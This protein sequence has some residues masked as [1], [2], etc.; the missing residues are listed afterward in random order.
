MTTVK[1]VLE[2]IDSLIPHP[3]EMESI[4]LDQ[5]LHR[6]L[7][8]SSQAMEDQP[9]FHRSSID[10]YLTHPDQ[11]TGKVRLLS[12]HLPKAPT[13]VLPSLITDCP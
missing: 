7:R 6:I 13:P 2:R 5:S 3:L 1:Q 11:P 9:P 10:G 12:P 4:P 8:E